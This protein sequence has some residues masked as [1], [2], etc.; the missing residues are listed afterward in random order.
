MVL[1]PAS[2]MLTNSS[3]NLHKTEHFRLGSMVVPRLFVGLWQLSSN[4]WGSAP[5]SKIY[6]GMDQ[7][8]KMGY[9]AFG[10]FIFIF[11]FK[12][13]QFTKICRHGKPFF[14]RRIQPFP[15]LFNYHQCMA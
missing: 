3:D 10:R 6:E 4:A 8:V 13:C 9:T 15:V 7:H 2:A 1:Q 5:V 12:G 11:L 14:F